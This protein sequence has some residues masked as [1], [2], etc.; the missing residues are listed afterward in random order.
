M[1]G[2]AEMVIQ[3]K[4]YKKFPMARDHKI[5]VTLEEYQLVRLSWEGTEILLELDDL[6]DL[7]RILQIADGKREEV[8]EVT[9][10]SIWKK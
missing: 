3:S 7:T 6:V 4:R 10:Y 5:K 8:K 2:N 9:S 1:I